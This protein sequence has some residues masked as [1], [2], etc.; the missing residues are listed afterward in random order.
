MHAEAKPDFDED[1]KAI[2][3]Q[4]FTEVAFLENLVRQRFTPMHMGN[5][6]TDEFG[7]LNHFFHFRK[8]TE[9]LKTLA[10][11]FQVDMAAMRAT[12]ACSLGMPISVALKR[13]VLT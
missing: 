6:T 8:N 1:H 12:T 13:W 10:W 3:L 4:L 2:L 5:L 11:C 7:V 9:K